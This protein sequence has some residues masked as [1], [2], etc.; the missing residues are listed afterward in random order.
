MNPDAYFL[1][2]CIDRERMHLLNVF[3]KL[4]WNY[5]QKR[6]LVRESLESEFAL[7]KSQ[8]QIE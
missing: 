5:R 7:K 6:L 8:F 2:C 1:H 4:R 3:S